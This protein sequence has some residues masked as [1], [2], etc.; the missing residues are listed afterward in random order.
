ME[1]LKNGLIITVFYFLTGCNSESEINTSNDSSSYSDTTEIVK[2]HLKYPDK[3]FIRFHVR[4]RR[5]EGLY[6]IYDSEGAII[7][8]II[9]KNGRGVGVEYEY[10]SNAPARI[11]EYEQIPGQLEYCVTGVQI[12]L[13]EGRLGSITRM[14]NS[15][16]HGFTYVFDK[17]E[18]LLL[19]GRYK[20]L[21]EDSLW[22]EYDTTGRIVNKEL[23]K[24]GNKIEK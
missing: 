20:N 1:L 12:N 11:R 13:I 8:Q 3:V 15:Y 17:N 19:S 23:F 22:L 16:P 9:F 18:R 7:E 14:L 2:Y 6:S 4:N 5:L 21:A 24:D 10:G